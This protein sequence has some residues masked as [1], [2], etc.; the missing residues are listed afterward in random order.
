MNKTKNNSLIVTAKNTKIQKNFSS[1]ILFMVAI[2]S[3]VIGLLAIIKTAYFNLV[4][5]FAN[6]KT[7]I[8]LDNIFL[9]I[10]FTLIIIGF[11]Y[12]LYKKILPKINK[13]ILFILM[14]VFS[15]SIGFW[16]VN[17]IKFRPIADQSLVVY[18]AEKFLDHDVKTILEPGEY[19]NR[20]PH[21]LGFVVYLMTIFKIFNTR[22]PIVAQNL[23]VLYSAI[24][25]IILYFIVKEIFE[26]DIVHKIALIFIIFFSI[27]FA[28]F[29]THV[30]GNIPGLMFGLIAL[31]F[32]LKFLESNK[33]WHLAIVAVTITISYLLKSNY[34]IFLFAI[35]IELLLKALKDWNIKNVF[36]AIVL[37]ILV[38]GLK[39][40]LYNHFEKATGY[41]LD[42]GVPMTSYIYMGI[43]EPVTLTPGWYTG[44]VEIIYNQSGYDSK[45]SEEIT[46]EV[47]KNRLKYLASNPKYTYDF[48]KNKLQTT[49]LNPTFQVFWCSTP[50]T[51]LDLDPAYNSRIAPKKLLISI[52][53]GRAYNIEERAMD[54]YQILIFLSASLALFTIFKEGSLKR[55]LLPIIFLGGF[56]FHFIW[57]TKAIYVLQYFYLLLPYAA[58]GLYKLLLLIDNKIKNKLEQ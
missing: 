17:Y 14:L 25:E 33:Y 37:F 27:Y 49:W 15:L 55:M 36:T 9:N 7:S 46:E 43:A 3:F 19:L 5:N 56:I 13:K 51:L 53:C 20:N 10:I 54:I 23:A 32:T 38:F 30:Y 29:C 6:E 39:S 12:F 41:S 42:T 26:E 18:C 44:D 4:I 40:I 28:F 34:E 35:V 48:F 24:S 2:I 8:K 45:K 57:E 21:Q 47:L 50:S 16:W 58:F 11:F 31:L 22:N 1:I 52:L